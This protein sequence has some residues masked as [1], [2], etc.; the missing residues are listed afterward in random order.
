LT[1]PL[2]Y[3]YTVIFLIACAVSTM[4][5]MSPV[6]AE[7]LGADYMSLGIMGA[8]HAGGYTVMTIITGLLM[9]RYEKIR[10]YVLFAALN[11]IAIGAFAFSNTVEQMILLRGLLG[12]A[13][14][15]FWVSSSSI[16]ASLSEPT[17]LTRNIGLY[18]LSWI[19][20]LAVGPLLGS[21]IAEYLGFKTLF[22]MLSFTVAFGLIIVVTKLMPFANLYGTRKKITIDFSALKTVS[23]AYFCLFPYTLSSGIYFS[24]LPGYMGELGI[25]A[26]IIGTLLTISNV[27]KGAGF[28]GVERLVNWG[29]KRAVRLIS[30]LLAISLASIAWVS[31]AWSIA[32]PLAIYGLANG[33]L[34]PILLNYIA[35]KSPPESRSFQMGIYET[36]FGVGMIIGPIATG[37]IIQSYPPSV[38]YLLLAVASLAI[39]PLSIWLEP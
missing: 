33:F 18:N 36:V 17:D 8:L 12:L 25:T 5:L 21:F 9:D 38:I 3:L 23:I 34:E 39:I 22:I 10:L 14:G 32:I 15:T 6:Y 4:M 26:S 20:G 2:R 37:F 11:V 19:T 16:T 30:V 28:F 27:A 13:S 31:E 24:I 1:K 29:T 35:Q 7:G